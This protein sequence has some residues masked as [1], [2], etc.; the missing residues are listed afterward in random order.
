LEV[1]RQVFWCNVGENIN[2]VVA[3]IIL[4]SKSQAIGTVPSSRD[5][6]DITEKMIEKVPTQFRGI[7]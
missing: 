3:L 6:V 5:E 1:D 4:T 7:I 2:F